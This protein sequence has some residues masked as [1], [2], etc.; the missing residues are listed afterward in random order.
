MNKTYLKQ[1]QRSE[2]MFLVTEFTGEIG[3]RLDGV[4]R[5]HDTDNGYTVMKY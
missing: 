2:L 5:N 1:D 3:T 4:E